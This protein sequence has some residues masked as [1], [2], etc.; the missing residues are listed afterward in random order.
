MLFLTVALYAIAAAIVLFANERSNPISDGTKRAWEYLEFITKRPHPFNSVYNEVV[1]DYLGD[2]IKSIIDN[3]AKYGDLY[4]HQTD[5]VKIAVSN[6]IVDFTAA[7]YPSNHIAYIAPRENKYP[8]AVVV[9]SAHYDSVSTSYG[10][11]DNGIAAAVLIS[12]I[13]YFQENRPLYQGI[14][15]NINN[16]EE[17]GL[18]GAFS[19]KQSEMVKGKN[20]TAFL[21]TDGAGAGGRSLLF[22]ASN[23]R[24]AG[25]YVGAKLPMVATTAN[26]FFQFGLLRSDTDFSAFASEPNAW[27]GIDIAYFQ[28]R[29]FYHTL[30]DSL[31][32]TDFDSVEHLYEVSRHTLESLS[33]DIPSDPANDVKQFMAA[34]LGVFSV[35]FDIKYFFIVNGVILAVAPLALFASYKKGKN[36]IHGMGIGTLSILLSAVGTGLLV[37][38]LAHINPNILHSQPNSVFMVILLSSVLTLTLAISL[39]SCIFKIDK[40]KLQ[41]SLQLESF[42]IFYLLLLLNSYIAVHFKFGSV[43]VITVAALFVFLTTIISVSCPKGSCIVKSSPK[44]EKKTMSKKSRATPTEAVASH[45][46]KHCCHGNMGLA[47]FAILIPSLIIYDGALIQTYLGLNQSMA[48]GSLPLMAY[49]LSAVPV[50][51]TAIISMPFLATVSLHKEFMPM[52]TVFLAL[53]AYCN[54]HFPFNSNA[55]MALYY[56][57]AI[58]L[59]TNFNEVSVLGYKGFVEKALEYIPSVK[60]SY[61]SCKPSKRGYHIRDCRY[62]GMPVNG[63]SSDSF[64]VKITKHSQSSTQLK[65]DI[66]NSK[67]CQLYSPGETIQLMKVN[68]TEY[69]RPVSKDSP[70]RMFLGSW[71]SSTDIYLAHDMASFKLNV[72]CFYDELEKLD[73]FQELH[74]YA[75]IWTNPSK[76]SPGLLKAYKIVDIK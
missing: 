54:L 34:F 4:E 47:A 17:D 32:H 10:A 21:N 68:E 5:E 7:L 1:G 56:E 53:F 27:S 42:G 76:Q 14:I 33:S 66:H 15:F 73:S 11:T 3:G 50:F 19:F 63:V 35:V 13:K 55:P 18:L 52:L 23:S 41:T 72:T 24:V 64:D 46:P 45:P 61:D 75:P 16:G 51:L 40:S 44:S 59:D 6:K 70:F 37:S 43:Y 31:S 60:I 58:N 26:D 36:E 8:N 69:D 22:R 67:I 20:V 49:T 74:Q 65:F 25:N 28:N 71:E 12:L 2:Q 38:T 62:E 39:L 57:Q 9:A 48:N 29:A 30:R